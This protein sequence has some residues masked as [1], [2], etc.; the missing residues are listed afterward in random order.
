MKT[1]IFSLRFGRI[2]LSYMKLVLSIFDPLQSVSQHACAWVFGTPER[3]V[4]EWV[5]L[6]L[7]ASSGTLVTQYDFKTLEDFGLTKMDFLRLK[8]LDVAAGTLARSR[9]LTNGIL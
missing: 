2:T 6:Y 7:I 8:T 5:P 1:P 9:S 3:P 4:A